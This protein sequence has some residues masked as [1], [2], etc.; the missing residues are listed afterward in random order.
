MIE[1]VHAPWII[2]WIAAVLYSLPGPTEA[3]ASIID[4]LIWPLVVL[5]LIFRF[6]IFLRHYLWVM[7]DRLERDHVKLG[8]FEIRAQDQVTVLD[9][10]VSGESTLSFQPDDID[11]VERIFEFIADS[12]NFSKLSEWVENTYG[13]DVDLEDFLTNP[14]YANHRA[15]AFRQVEGLG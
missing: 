13:K 11:H 3:W 9:P 15:Q 5:F 14:S 4:T 7:A 12:A 10:S 1:P 2:R 6:R 8:W